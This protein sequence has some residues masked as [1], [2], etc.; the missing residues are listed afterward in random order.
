MG[1]QHRINAEKC[2]LLIEKKHGYDR[3]RHFS[4]YLY[5]FN[6]VNALTGHLPTFK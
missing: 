3:R 1:T 5:K 2:Y 4:S 6:M